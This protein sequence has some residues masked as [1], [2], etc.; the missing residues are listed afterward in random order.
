MIG[1]D[2]SDDARGGWGVLIEKL[3]LIM[4]AVYVANL[5]GIKSEVLEKGVMFFF[6]IGRTETLFCIVSILKSVHW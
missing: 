3:N 6:V 4:W 1:K 5:W 2:A